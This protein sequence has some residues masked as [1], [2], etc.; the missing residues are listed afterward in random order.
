VSGPRNGKKTERI[1]F[2]V[3][4]WCIGLRIRHC[5]LSGLDLARSLATF[6]CHGHGQ[7]EKRKS[8]FCKRTYQRRS[9][10]DFDRGNFSGVVEMKA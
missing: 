1:G 2:G 10:H 4:W 7:K 6:S 3:P 5:H 9:L 8:W